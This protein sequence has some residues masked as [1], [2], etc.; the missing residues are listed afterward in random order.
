[1]AALFREK[2]VDSNG[3]LSAQ[4]ISDGLRWPTEECDR[5][6]AEFDESRNGELEFLEFL[7]MMR[8]A[9][10][11]STRSLAQAD[12]IAGQRALGRA[13]GL[14]PD[15][16]RQRAATFKECDTNGDARLSP[17]ELAEGFG[18]DRAKIEAIFQEHDRD[19]DGSIDFFEFLALSKTSQEL[20]VLPD[21]DDGNCRV[22]RKEINGGVSIGG[23]SF[24]ND[25]FRCNGCGKAF[26][27]EGT[28]SSPN[29]R[30][31]FFCS[32]CYAEE[33]CPK[34]FICVKPCSGSYITVQEKTC[35]AECF[36]C[37]GCGSPLQGSF[38]T[39]RGKHICSRCMN[40]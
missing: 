34:C 29:G 32:D 28:F 8:T 21:A 27:N 6:I 30:K 33:F 35:H 2:D 22:C 40:P 25:C 3:A 1:L 11:R 37:D 4:E 13:F 10:E 14:S 17:Q 24:H 39:D 36:K 15:D 19:S 12:S 7:A 9:R 20:R 26:G 5:L 16:V 38:F 23:F 31:R 18:W